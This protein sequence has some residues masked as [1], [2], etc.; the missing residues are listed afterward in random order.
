MSELGLRQ[1]LKKDI[2]MQ[3]KSAM[4]YRMLDESLAEYDRVERLGEC[5]NRVID[6]AAGLEKAKREDVGEFQALTSGL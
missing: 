6:I 3:R 2:A 1:K 4:Q 5:Y